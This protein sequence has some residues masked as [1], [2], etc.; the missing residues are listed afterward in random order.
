MLG[1]PGDKEFNHKQLFQGDNPAQPY[2]KEPPKPVEEEGWREPVG[3]VSMDI[4][5]EPD[6]KPKRKPK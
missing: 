2:V 5:T 1:A 3:D 6:E 4:F